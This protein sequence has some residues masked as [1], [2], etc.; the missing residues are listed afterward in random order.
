MISDNP[1][2]RQAVEVTAAFT[3]I[4][5]I[6][7]ALRLYTRFFLVRCPGVEDYMIAVAMISSI[8]LTVCVGFQA[9]WGMGLHVWQID[10]TTTVKSLQAFWASIMFYNGGLTLTKASIL[11]QYRRV[12]TTRWFQIACWVNI[13]F[14]VA[15]SL[16]ALATT[17]FLC[18]PVRAFWTKEPGARCINQFAIWF[19]NA[20]VNIVQDF[21]LIILPMPVIRSLNL[22][23]RQKGALIGI[24]AVGGFVCIVSILRLQSLISIS[25][26]SD[27]TYDNPPAATWS[28][29]ETNVGIICS[30]LPLMRPLVTRWLP[31]IFSSHKRS[32]NGP[33][34]YSNIGTSRLTR[35]HLSRNEIAL[36]ATRRSQHSDDD[37]GDIQVITDI[38]VQVEEDESK[39]DEWRT[40][41]STKEW[42]EIRSN[43]NTQRAS[44]S[45]DTLVKEPSRVV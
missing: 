39:I 37:N 33:R 13:A 17:I 31:G 9:S 30:C 41:I 28:A 2:G 7:V 38:R 22:G 8:G 1:R 3:G 21:I 42:T 20:A 44:S 35:E 19:T 15:Y 18:V 14:V 34:P 43:A 29:V 36:R 5:I 32:Q 27:P 12:F 11:L 26:S 24:F 4:A 45:T 10:P 40:E 16:F 6:V 25:N 23:K